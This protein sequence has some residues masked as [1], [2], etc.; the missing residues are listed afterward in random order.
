LS[1][2]TSNAAEYKRVLSHLKKDRIEFLRITIEGLLRRIVG[3]LIKM[4]LRE[5]TYLTIRSR[6]RKLHILK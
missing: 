4:G 3:I 2:V 6:L 5:N 1:A